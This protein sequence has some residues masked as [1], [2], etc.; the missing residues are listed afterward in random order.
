MYLAS[1]GSYSDA[2]QVDCIL[3]LSIPDTATG[4]LFFYPEGSQSDSISVGVAAMFRFGAP[5]YSISIALNILLTLMITARLTM[6]RRDIQNAMGAAACGSYTATITVIVESCALNAV[7]TILYLG[8]WAAKSLVQYIFLQLLVQTQVRAVF[9]IFL[10]HRDLRKLWSNRR[11]EQVIAPFL[12]ILRIANRRAVTS[13]NFTSES[14]RFRSR[15]MPTD[16][17]GTLSGQYPLSLMDAGDLGVG[18]RRP[19][20]P[21]VTASQGRKGP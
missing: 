2:P 20:I 19:S 11:L 8:T 15:G 14:I 16:G 13:D 1:I 5:Y 21:T 4:I 3:L 10:T 17:S 12:I 7:I 9:L 18:V 6:H